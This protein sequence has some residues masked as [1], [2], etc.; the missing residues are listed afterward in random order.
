MVG[1]IVDGGIA[2]NLDLV[3]KDVNHPCRLHKG[4]GDSG[5]FM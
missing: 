1:G 4:T 5:I 2:D 3:A